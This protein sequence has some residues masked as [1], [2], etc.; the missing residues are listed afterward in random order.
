MAAQTEKHKDIQVPTHPNT[1]VLHIIHTICFGGI[2]FI[3][4]RIK[5][6]IQATLSAR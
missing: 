2:K 6:N 4:I 3:I 1:I 5:K